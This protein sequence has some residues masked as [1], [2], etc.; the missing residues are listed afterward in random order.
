MNVTRGSVQFSVG[1]DHDAFWA[2][3]VDGD[4]EPASYA[5]LD[6]FLAP[7]LIMV[8]IGAWI[9]PLTLY[10]AG[11]KARVLAYEPDPVARAELAANLAL[12]PELAERVTILPLAVGPGAAE[13]RL[14]N[15]TSARGGDSMSSL[16]FAD[17]RVGWPVRSVGLTD[18]LSAIPAEL[19]GLVK[20]DIEGA[21]AEML[22]PAAE[23]LA[24]AQPPLFLSVH[25]RF[26]QPDPLP[27]LRRLADLLAAYEVLLAPDFEPLPPE[28]FLTEPYA[29]GLFELVACSRQCWETR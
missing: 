23:L 9:G 28:R 6:R 13:V 8:D 29:G 1:G 22:E 4:W 18:V 27:R 19:L 12:N 2:R 26:W 17:A 11:L 3:V 5:V 7:D 21:E 15:R 24:R 20:I 16:L 25:A 10:A 14:G